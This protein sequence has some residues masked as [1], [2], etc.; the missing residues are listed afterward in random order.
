MNFLIGFL[1]LGLGRALSMKVKKAFPPTVVLLAFGIFN[2]V[3]RTLSWQL[4]LVYFLILLAVWLSHK[5]FYHKKFVYSWGAI[6]FD[7]SLFTFLFVV[8]AIVGYHSG[9]FWSNKFTANHFIL[10]PSDEVWF[11]GLGFRSFFTGVS[12][13]LSIFSYDTF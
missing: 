13:T 9:S 3:T 2:T 8:Y 4:I 7:T 1:L 6:F 11:S 10:F 5:E 12:C